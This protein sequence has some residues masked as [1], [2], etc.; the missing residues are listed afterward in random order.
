[1]LP[2][3]ENRSG[4]TFTRDE[5]CF[6]RKDCGELRPGGGSWSKGLRLPER[7][8]ARL[9]WMDREEL[10]IGSGSWSE[11][12]SLPEREEDFLEER[13]ERVIGIRIGVTT[14]AL[15]SHYTA[16]CRNFLI[17]VVKKKEKT[18]ILLQIY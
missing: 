3:I 15:L 2:R 17:A 6:G 1:M 10:R 9:C 11:G 16:S 13:F 14:S 5:E 8:E 7:A 12:L 4:D 18:T